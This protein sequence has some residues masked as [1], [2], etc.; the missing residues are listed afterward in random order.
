M[1]EPRT[2]LPVARGSMPAAT[3]AADPDDEPPGVRVVSQG[4]HVGAGSAM[5]SSVEWVL[6]TMTAPP[7]RSASTWAASMA[8]TLPA[9]MRLPTSVGR[10]ATSKQSLIPTGS[11][12]TAE[13]GLPSRQRA[14]AASAACARALEI[15][16]HEG[17]DRGLQ[18]G[19]AFET[20]LEIC[21]ADCRARPRTQPAPRRSTDSARCAGRRTWGSFR[22]VVLP[23]PSSRGGLEA[24]EAI[25]GRLLR[26]ARNDN[27]CV[28]V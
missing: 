17:L 6:P 3:H 4:F 26:F 25:S 9:N 5:V 19:D 23:V 18:L 13:S 7:R 12:S 16:A 11:P 15:E 10:P 27:R 1:I 14:L 20:A 24:D 21:R 28:N 22:L 8:A 2:W